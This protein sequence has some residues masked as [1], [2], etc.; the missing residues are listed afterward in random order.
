MKVTVKLSFRLPP[1]GWRT[2]HHSLPGNNS[3][4]PTTELV[5]GSNRVRMG[6]KKRLG[7]QRG[8]LARNKR[9]GKTLRYFGCGNSSS[10]F[11]GDGVHEDIFCVH[12]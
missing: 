2:L 10:V 11:G 12:V 4:P 3:R 9:G 7:Y 1:T 8:G 5:R 6:K